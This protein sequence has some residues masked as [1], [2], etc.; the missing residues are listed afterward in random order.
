VVKSW[1]AR[2]VY[3]YHEECARIYYLLAYPKNVA[4]AISE[5]GKAQLK[6]AIRQ[7]KVEKC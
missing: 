2:I 3:Y 7:L 5:P 1:G 6:N 4:V